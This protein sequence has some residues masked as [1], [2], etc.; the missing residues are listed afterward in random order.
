M[1]RFRMA[2]V[3]LL[4][5]LVLGA[6][7]WV[8]HARQ[9]VRGPIAAALPRIAGPRAPADVRVRVQVLNTTKTRGLARRATRVLRDRGFDVVELGT[10]TP[11][12]DTTLVLDRSGH[13]AWAST[14]AE[15]LQPARAVAR[16]DSS[17]YL[18]VTVLLGRT[19]RPPSHPLDP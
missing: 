10:T 19:W 2:A 8:L 17:R 4:V 14:V 5:L 13:P 16:P 9:V 3:A 1:S 15:L 18:D 7:T 11:M 6:A 12:L